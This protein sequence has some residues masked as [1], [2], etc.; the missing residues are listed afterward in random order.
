MSRDVSGI[1]AWLR[2][3]FDDIYQSKLVSGSNIKTI[4]NNSLLGSGNINIQGGG[5]NVD[6]TTSWGN[7][8]SDSK[9]PSEKLA[10]DSLDNKSNLNHT[11][12]KEDID[13]QTT[14]SSFNIHLYET[15]EYMINRNEFVIPH[16]EKALFDFASILLNDGDYV[17]FKIT[18]TGGGSY[19]IYS[20]DGVYAYSVGD[21]PS[22]KIINDNG[23]MYT[24]FYNE[25]GS[26]QARRGNSVGIRIR[27]FGTPD[28]IGYFSSKVYLRKASWLDMI[29]PIGSIYISTYNRNPS[30]YFG[31]EWEQ[32]EDRFLLASGSTYTNGDTGGEAT[33]SLTESEMPRHTHIQNSHNHTQNPHHHDLNRRWSNGTGSDGAYAQASNRSYQSIRTKDTTATNNAQTATN[34]YTGGN[35]SIGESAGNGVAHNNM[36]P[37]MVVSVWERLS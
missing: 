18:K 32:I 35:T 4:N 28:L 14:T 1:V 37:Y 21:N 26:L 3:F 16:G 13:F 2:S 30:L 20:S 33:H 31:G 22:I 7:P 6:I 25:N 17:S 15:T 9:V 5:G 12:I 8:T 23:V 11:H 34:K 24:E 27:N 10:K 29:Y 36:P 19:I